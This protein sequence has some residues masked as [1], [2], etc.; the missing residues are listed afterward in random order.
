[1]QQT[2]PQTVVRAERNTSEAGSNARTHLVVEEER[3]LLRRH[4][5]RLKGQDKAARHA[6]HAAS[7][8]AV[9]ATD[10]PDQCA[11]LRVHPKSA[12]PPAH[13]LWQR[14]HGALAP[15]GSCWRD[16]AAPRTTAATAASAAVVRRRLEQNMSVRALKSKC[17]G[18]QCSA[19]L[20][21]CGL[22]VLRAR[23]RLAGQVPRLALACQGSQGKDRKRKTTIVQNPMLGHPK[24]R[25]RHSFFAQATRQRAVMT[26]KIPF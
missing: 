14:R 13:L 1:M 4:Q 18:A 19:L 12:P 3:Q 16:A 5:L 17:T 6:A 22:L 21:G 20:G 25:H 10:E 8:T 15:S 9:Q 11:D 2:A 24:K 23:R 7:V 26:A